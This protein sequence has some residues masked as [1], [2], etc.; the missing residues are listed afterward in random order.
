MYVVAYKGRNWPSDRDGPNVALTVWRP[1]KNE[2]FQFYI[3]VFP[4]TASFDLLA[5]SG[6]RP[7]GTGNR[8]YQALTVATI[9]EIER[10][11]RG[12]YL[13][14]ADETRRIEARFLFP[15]PARVRELQSGPNSLPEIH[16]GLFGGH[17]VHQFDA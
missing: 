5:P 11:I 13:P 12:G 9:E 10:D 17:E 3:G 4:T 16:D 15:E 8:W 14:A 2:Y 1:D 7:S 6:P